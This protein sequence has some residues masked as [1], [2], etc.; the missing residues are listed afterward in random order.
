MRFRHGVSITITTLCRLSITEKRKNVGNFVIAFMHQKSG[1]SS[2]HMTLHETRWNFEF[3]VKVASVLLAFLLNPLPI[4]LVYFSTYIFV[5]NE[6]GECSGRRITWKAHSF[7]EIRTLTTTSRAE[8]TTGGKITHLIVFFF[9]LFKA[10]R[11][12]IEHTTM[13]GQQAT[14]SIVFEAVRLT[15]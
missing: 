14:L 12:A 6:H 3:I 8:V 7:I 5:S 1:E 10:F 13:D 15:T 11:F 4:L 9:A 2:T